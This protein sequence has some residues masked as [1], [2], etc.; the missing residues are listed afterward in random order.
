MR[1][2]S[3]A[4]RYD[5]RV[6]LGGRTRRRPLVTLLALASALAGPTAA[7]AAEPV[8]IYRDAF[9]VPH[10]EGPSDLA[11]SYGTGF[12]LAEDRLFET[13]GI[14]LLAQG[15]LSELVGRDSLEADYVMRR[16]FYDPLDVQR[17]YEAF[18]Q[19][20]KRELEAFVAG[21]NAGMREVMA[22]PSRRPA[23]FDALGY[24]PEPY[25]PTDT[26]SVLML[27]SYVNF[28]GEGGAGQLANAELLA[29]LQRRYGSRRGLSMWNDLVFKNDPGAPTV[30]PRGE[31]TR[32]P[33]S[34]TGERQPGAAQQ[35]LARALAAVLGRAAE[36]RRAESRRVEAFFRRVPLLPKI[37]SY[38][39]AVAGRR[40]RSGGA[41]LLGS[42]QAGLSAPS[43]FWQLGQH[44]PSRSCTG[45]TVP[46]LGPYAGIGWCNG[47]AWSLV[48]GNAGDQVDNYVER[49]NPRDPR[50]YRYRG[51]YRD[52]D[53]RTE[54]FRVNRC[55]PPVCSEPS[56]ASTETRE[57]ESTV[58]GP[59]VRRDNAAGI[60][61]TQ[62]R[63]QRGAWAR[64]IETVA[65]WNRA[66]S[67]REFDR[68]SDAAGGTYNMLYGD[69]RGHI[70]YRFT[71][72]QPV[73]PRGIDRRLPSP[74][75]GSAEWP[76]MVPRRAL[77]RVSDPRS[78]ILVTNQGVESKPSSWWPNSS[79]V[80][81]GQASRVAGNVRI[82][83]RA[84]RLDADRL[85]RL[86]PLLLERRD[87]ITPI[88]AA[89]LRAALRPSRDSR[90]R[91]ALRLFD[92][93]SA[94]GFPREDRDGDGK[95]DHPGFTIFNADNFDLPGDK[96][97]RHLWND[98]RDRL[99]LD[100]FGERRG[101]DSRG[102]FAAPGGYLGQLS[103]LKVALDG[104]RAS[105]RLSRDY[106]D[107]VRTRRRERAAAQVQ[108]SVR[109]ALAALEKEFGTADMRR[110][111]RPVPMQEFEALGVV[112][113]PPIRGFDHG[114]Y[115]Q[116]VD[117]RAGVGRY[118]LPPG[119][120]SADSA[121]DIAL[122]QN[123]QYPKHFVDQ[124]E[125]YERY[126][127]LTMPHRPDQFRAGTESIRTLEYPG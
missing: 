117:P 105:R 54:T 16:D 70:L 4:G 56:P 7:A 25:T 21:F 121:S 88:F 28:A 30:V 38:A 62:R 57:I 8:T 1:G 49:L 91:R 6:T 51:R 34:V 52:M 59:V 112:A 123:G 103:T 24:A 81:I 120:G 55:A 18:S 26:V 33:R 82:L 2:S 114:T 63:A 36:S 71:G 13:V 113:P 12:A 10:V 47:H 5:A 27:F 93:W 68:F 48:A 94:A 86:N 44:S 69:G 78:G 17:Q 125:V 85:Q 122:A 124:R 102:T 104:R 72:M 20:R 58:H 83:A 79:S 116:I 53:V 90:L 87:V 35:R 126:G 11:V 61:I 110:W 60:A 127:F 107:D 39:A 31:G 119:N 96:Y 14:R 73:R 45:F 108:A 64:A 111:L 67:I 22:D 42:P 109:V 77:P 80:M 92:E 40:T 37:G 106:V 75:D 50:Q 41:L 118:I 19:E 95:Y 29:K 97:P 98:L 3:A 46:G 23:A 32:A 115:S 66:R 74:G 89:H 15:R 65:G 99:F 43:V 9:G 101:S 84:G 76:G 100:E